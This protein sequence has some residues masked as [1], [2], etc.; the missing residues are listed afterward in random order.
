MRP[1]RMNQRCR[2]SMIGAAYFRAAQAYMLISMPTGTST[3][4]GVF[5]A[6]RALLS[7][8]IQDGGPYP[9]SGKKLTRGRRFVMRK[10][11]RRPAQIRD[12]GAVQQTP[13]C[14]ALQTIQPQ[15]RISEHR[16]VAAAL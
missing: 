14:A 13:G 16:S 5:Q 12:R 2:L 3:I 15:A 10:A 11:A 6:I 8:S 4:F 9:D 1:H 7:E